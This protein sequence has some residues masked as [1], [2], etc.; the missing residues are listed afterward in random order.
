MLNR[1]VIVE[2]AVGFNSFNKLNYHSH[3]TSR[4]LSS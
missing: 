3:W 1:G 2:K 4:D